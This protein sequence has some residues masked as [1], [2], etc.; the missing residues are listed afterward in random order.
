MTTTY[1]R[2]FQKRYTTAAATLASVTLESGE[3]MLDLTTG[4]LYCPVTGGS[5]FNTEKPFRRDGMLA[6]PSAV[7][8]NEI[9]RWDGT[10]GYTIQ[11]SGVKIA[12]GSAGTLSPTG[13][14][15][16]TWTASVTLA[17]TDGKTLTLSDNATITT[18]GATVTGAA[19]AAA[20]RT[21]LGLGSM[22][23]QSAGSV[24][25][26]GG[27]ITGMSSPSASSDVATKG[28]VDGLVNGVSWKP[29][30][31]VATTGAGTLATSFENGDTVDGVVLATGDRI[32]IKDQAS[33]SEN[34][35]YV[36]A[37]SGAPARAADADASA[38]LLGVAVLVREGTSNADKAFVCTNDSVNLGVTSLV[39]TQMAGG[40][41]VSSVGLSLPAEF[42]VSGSPVTGTGTLTASWAAQSGSKFFASPAGGGSGT[43]G[44]RAIVRSDFGSYVEAN[45]GAVLR[46]PVNTAGGN[47]TMISG[48]AYWTYVG[49][50]PIAEVVKRIRLYVVTGGTGAQ[51]AEVAVST[52]TTAPTGSNITLTKVWADGSLDALTGTGRLGNSADNS[53]ALSG[54]AHCWVGIRSAMATTQ[55]TVRALAYDFGDGYLATTAASGAL[56]GA[57]PWTATPFAATGQFPD[58]RGYL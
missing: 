7:A 10:D 49:Y 54:D 24:S 2:M 58:V 16:L 28:Y 34:G 45:A 25:I 48:T 21:A 43:P 9:P 22:A 31:R 42:S 32:L 11:S 46:S 56:T 26:S 19:D 39:W 14:K 53:T 47:M 8:D 3:F 6:A 17:G 35:I 52:S 44:M 57:G 29:S 38:E 13:S 41:G 27:S 40:G 50:R 30:V 18:F 15:S 37:A 5:G 20:G 33:G 4:H 12:D 51:T 1:A 23:T 36:V 55:P